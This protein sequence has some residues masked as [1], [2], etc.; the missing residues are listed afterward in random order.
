MPVN[1]LAIEAIGRLVESAVELIPQLVD[2]IKEGR[3]RDVRDT[4]E[5]MARREAFEAKQKAKG[6]I[7]GS[8]HPEA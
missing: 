7:G 5:E 6:V 4:A 8:E 2:A 3:A 1:T